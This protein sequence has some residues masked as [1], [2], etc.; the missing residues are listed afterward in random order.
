[1]PQKALA[2]TLALLMTPTLYAAA[3]G[4]I[5]TGENGRKWGENTLEQGKYTMCQGSFPGVTNA[6]FDNIAT[7]TCRSVTYQVEYPYVTLTKILFASLNCADCDLEV[8]ETNGSTTRFIAGKD[9]MTSEV[10]HT[11]PATAVTYTQFWVRE[12]ESPVAPEA[13]GSEPLRTFAVTFTVCN[14]DPSSDDDA[15]VY[16]CYTSAR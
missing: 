12:L 15:I 3:D 11:A 10:L 4:N 5:K 8:T 1:M 16:A 9:D 14:N 7:G 13:A 6:E 2:L